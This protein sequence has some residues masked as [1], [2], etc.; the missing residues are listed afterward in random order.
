MSKKPLLCNYAWGHLDFHT[1]GYYTPC[2][3]FNPN[4]QK[5]KKV[6]ESL[7]S[8]AMNSTEMKAVRSQLLSGEWPS[9][10]FECKNKEAKG[11]RSYRQESVMENVTWKGF[12]PDYNNVNIKNYHEIEIKFS[13]TCNLFCR[14]CNSLSNSRFEI[15]GKKFPHLK[16][17]FEKVDFTHLS[18]PKKH[19]A[20]ISEEVIDDLVKNIIPG[21]SR[22]MFGGGEPLYH[23]AHYK[24]LETLINDSNINTKNII[25]EYNTNLSMISFKKYQLADLWEKFKAVR[26]TVSVDGTGK[27]FNY[28]RQNA[29]YDQMLKNVHSILNNCSTVNHLT[30]VCTSTAYHAFYM[31]KIINNFSTELTGIRAQ[32]N[33][34]THFKLTFVHYPEAL[35]MVNLD[36]NVKKFIIENTEKSYTPEFYPEAT[37]YSYEHAFKEFYTYIKNEKNKEVDFIKVAKLQDELHNIDAFTLVPRLAEYIYNGRLV[38]ND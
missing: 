18:E 7:P 33:I 36:A 29:D 3:R 31:D 27:L 28:F 34:N 38:W 6:T 12:E 32:Y 15:L 19:I 14:H 23:L 2:F 17:E 37:R 13:R 5:M 30:F 10:C 26:V 8:E 16:K 35:D 21:V 20:E 22:I 25:L 9:G 1:K 4:E 11:I 24:F